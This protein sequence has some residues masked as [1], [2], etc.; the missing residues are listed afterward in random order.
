MTR[1][2][3]ADN[4]ALAIGGSGG[5]GRV[6]AAQLAAQGPNVC[7][8]GR[9]GGNVSAALHKLHAANADQAVEAMCNSSASRRE[10]AIQP[11]REP[12]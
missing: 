3:F 9:S 5:I 12:E 1:K 4:A 6:V 11:F 8:T 7:I 2:I 10:V